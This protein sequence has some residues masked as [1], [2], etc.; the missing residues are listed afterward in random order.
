MKEG[1]EERLK[2]V[3][4]KIKKINED[5]TAITPYTLKRTAKKFG[6]SSHVI[7]PKDFEGKEILVIKFPLERKK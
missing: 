3:S 5:L 4:K 1:V 7:L 6:K 2:E